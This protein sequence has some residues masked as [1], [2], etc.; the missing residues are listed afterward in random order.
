MKQRKCGIKLMALLMSA[1]FLANVPRME[2]SAAEA[3]SVVDEEVEVLEATVINGGE[4]GEKTNS[5]AR[6]FLV[7]CMINTYSSSKGLLV[8]C[9][10]D[11]T[12]TASVLGVKD[13]KIQKKVWY[14]WKTVATSTG[15]EEYN[16]EMMGCSVLYSNAEYGETYRISCVHYGNVDGYNEVENQ[17]EGIVFTY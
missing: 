10:T 15:G 8:E 12:Q 2:V 4:I 1:M 9:F 11:A 7:N 5:N 17:T 6:T 13:I 16:T 3:Q 14:G